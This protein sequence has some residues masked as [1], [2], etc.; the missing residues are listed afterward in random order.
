MS[1]NFFDDFTAGAVPTA[2]EFT[3][4]GV[5]KTIHIKQLTASQKLQ[6]DRGQAINVST[7][8]KKVAADQRMQVDLGDF[9]QKRQMRVMFC[10]VDESGKQRFK[11]LGEVQ[12]QP[13]NLISALAK[14]VEEETGEEPGK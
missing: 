14:L 12:L 8:G 2:R 11:N 7:G 13:A 5:T 1:H 4:N 10:V 9:E 3:Y 6:L